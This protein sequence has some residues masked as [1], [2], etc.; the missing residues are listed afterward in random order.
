[1]WKGEGKRR[2]VAAYLSPKGSGEKR[3]KGPSRGM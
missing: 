1:M 2:E 3:G